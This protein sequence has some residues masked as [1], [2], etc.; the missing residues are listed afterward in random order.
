MSWPRCTG[1]PTAIAS[2]PAHAG[3]G[4]WLVGTSSLADW[5]Q[6]GRVLR[7][8]A[9]AGR[10]RR[11]RDLGVDTAPDP[12]ADEARLLAHLDAQGGRRTAPGARR[13]TAT[14]GCSTRRRAE[15]GALRRA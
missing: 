10:R 5:P 13:W 2:S 11:A 15:H 6:Q 9:T 1:T 4:F 7:V 12:L 3:G 14:S 8:R